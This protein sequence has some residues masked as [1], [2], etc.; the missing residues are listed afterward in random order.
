MSE[1][2]LSAEL[3]QISPE[4]LQIRRAQRGAPFR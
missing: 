2:K 1:L 4:V 3:L